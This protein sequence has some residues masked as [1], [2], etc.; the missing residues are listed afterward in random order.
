MLSAHQSALEDVAQARKRL[1]ECG[2]RKLGNST[3]ELFTH[4]KSALSQNGAVP[5]VSD[6]EVPVTGA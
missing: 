4:A 3:A 5:Q 2:R 1:A 6:G